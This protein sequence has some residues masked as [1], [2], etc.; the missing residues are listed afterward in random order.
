MS[1]LDSTSLTST[2]PLL[3]LPPIRDMPSGWLWVPTLLLLL[4]LPLE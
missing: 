2:L 1:F 3:P 4:L